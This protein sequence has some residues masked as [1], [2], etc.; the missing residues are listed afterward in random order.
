[1]V[2]VQSQ[3]AVGIAMP[4]AQAM[5]HL[6]IAANRFT[7]FFYPLDHSAI[8]RKRMII[9]PIV[10]AL[11]L[12]ILVYVGAY[13]GLRLIPDNG[14]HETIWDVF[15]YFYIP[16]GSRTRKRFILHERRT[17]KG[18]S[19]LTCP[20]VRNI[21]KIAQGNRYVAADGCLCDKFGSWKG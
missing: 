3:N 16:V 11:V 1:M 20:G 17:G 10:V 9:G 7:A 13:Y 5:L 19:P 12:S 14:S 6:L 4:C 2:Y 21:R 15:T 18:I 8:W